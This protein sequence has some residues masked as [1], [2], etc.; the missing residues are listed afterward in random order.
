MPATEML[1]KRSV[2]DIFPNVKTD[3]E[4]FIKNRSEDNVK[5]K[6]KSKLNRMRNIVRKLIHRENK[7]KANY[8]KQNMKKVLGTI[9]AQNYHRL[10]TSI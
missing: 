9:N 4:I 6:Y 2:F 3:N 10:L 5:S 8:I 1:Q 7:N